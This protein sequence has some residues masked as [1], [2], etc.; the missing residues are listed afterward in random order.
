MKL[1]IDHVR[2]G[3]VLDIEQG[4]NITFKATSIHS[5]GEEEELFSD[6]IKVFIYSV[7]MEN[8]NNYDVSV[9]IKKKSESEL[10]PY[11]VKEKFFK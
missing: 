7:L 1:S 2:N 4:A 5:D 9:K 10:K 8:I 6:A 3:Y 11:E